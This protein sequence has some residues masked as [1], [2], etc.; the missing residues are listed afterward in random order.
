M[1]RPLDDHPFILLLTRFSVP[2]LIL[3]FYVTAALRFAYTPESTFAALVAL[4]GS[5]VSSLWS[6]LLTLAS[7][8]TIDP[9]LAAKVFSMVS[10][11]FALLFSY[12]IAREVLGERL[13]ALCVVLA[14]S[15]QA[16]LVQLAPS[17][18]GV[19][20][21][22]LLTLAALF[23]LLRNDYL[24][25]SVVGGVAALV[26]W[27]NILLLP[28]VVFDAYIN[29]V[30]RSRSA[31]VALSIMLVFASVLL[32]WILY[33]LYSGMVL[34]PDEVGRSDV[35]TFLPHLSFEMVFLVGVLFVGVAM[36]ASRER[37]VLRVH[38]APLLWIAV[39]SFMH[40]VMFALT[41]PM[42]VVYAFFSV[43]HVIMSLGKE[44]L[45][46]VGGIVLTALLLAYNQ[47]VV[48]PATTALMEEVSTTSAGLKSA[49]LWLRTNAREDEA[50]SVPA[51][52]NSLIEFYV[53]RPVTDTDARFLITADRQVAGFEV[54][55]DPVEENPAL[56]AATAR[57][58]V[59]RRK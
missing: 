16:W 55:F 48:L 18:S 30:Q 22:L 31:K 42:I 59:W 26:S 4:Q 37:Q 43:Q 21:A 24:V 33:A 27:Q 28:I 52:H 54:V 20:V 7:L 6:A 13:L 40:R 5:P 49:A 35:P 47:L 3:I 25:A 2:A 10:C 1:A 8:L 34:V 45:V 58:K 15:M 38:T 39:A 32:P 50:I 36:L 11:C 23:F 41:L 57:Y 17:G 19:S 51:E 14:L 56:L 29:S 44:R 46:Q 53:A 9:W 12:L